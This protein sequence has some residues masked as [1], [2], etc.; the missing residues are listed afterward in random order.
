[1]PAQQKVTVTRIA[2][3]LGASRSGWLAAKFGRLRLKPVEGR[4]QTPRLLQPVTVS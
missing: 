3:I 1:M 2:C 4:D